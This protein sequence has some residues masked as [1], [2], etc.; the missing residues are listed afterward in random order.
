EIQKYLAGKFE[1]TLRVKPEEVTAGLGAAVRT[2]AG[3][4]EERLAA[5]QKQRRLFSKIQALYDVGPPPR[6]HLLKRGNHETP[7]EEVEPGFF[8]VLSEPGQQPMVAPSATSSG[9]R[10]ALANW[11]TKRDSRPAA[12]LARVMV[13]RLWQH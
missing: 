9:R 5:L 11:L 13:N 1:N 3:K 10:T 8:A 12:L 4:I 6:T 7:G 2:A